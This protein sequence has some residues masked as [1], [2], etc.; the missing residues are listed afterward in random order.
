MGNI[1]SKHR[2]HQE[3]VRIQNQFD[4]YFR[5]HKRKFIWDKQLQLDQLNTSDPADF[6][7]QIKK[8]GPRSSD[9]P[10]LDVYDDEGHM[11]ADI[12]CVLDTWSN[13]F[14]KLY[15]AYE[16][17]DNV[18]DKKNLWSKTSGIRYVG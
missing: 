1:R 4:A 14:G 3:F 15:V 8:L 10:P 11:T 17:A 9:G 6:W 13:T 7:W 5:H 2:K 12:N 16:D 18:F